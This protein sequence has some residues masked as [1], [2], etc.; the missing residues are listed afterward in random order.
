MNATQRGQPPG[1]RASRTTSSP[2]APG[3]SD[4]QCNGRCRGR[5]RRVPPRVQPPP[6]R[7]A[8]PVATPNSIALV[9]TKG[10]G[11]GITIKRYCRWRPLRAFTG[12]ARPGG[13]PEHASTGGSHPPEGAAPANRSPRS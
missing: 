13:L 8:S 3:E 12:A 5:M 11:S 6:R 2:T 1:G 7:P 4:D 9:N 10:R